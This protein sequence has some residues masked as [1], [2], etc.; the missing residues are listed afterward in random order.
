MNEMLDLHDE[1]PEGKGLRHTDDEARSSTNNEQRGQ[2]EEDI[3][4]GL[5]DRGVM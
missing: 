1:R 3:D 5:L 2:E 4:P